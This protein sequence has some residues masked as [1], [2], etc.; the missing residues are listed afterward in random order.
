MMVRGVD[1][2]FATP[3]SDSEDRRTEIEEDHNSAQRKRRK[4]KGRY[5]TSD[6]ACY[7]LVSE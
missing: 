5:D 1:P 2:R 3:I 6:T 4:M 7:S